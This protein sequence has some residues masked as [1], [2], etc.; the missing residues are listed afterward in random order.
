MANGVVQPEEQRSEV[1]EETR[2]P[3]EVVLSRIIWWILGVV[4]VLLGLRFVLELL[5]AN[6]RAPFVQLVYAISDVLMIPFTAVFRTS[7]VAGA[8]FDWST[9]LAMVVYALI[10]WGLVSLVR[11]LSPRRS[12][13]TYER[14]VRH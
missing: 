6:A 1:H 13:G 7:R 5:G 8:T 4:E 3:V 2:S 9:L 10:A 12:A 14:V 11:A